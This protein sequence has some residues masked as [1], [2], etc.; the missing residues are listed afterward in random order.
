LT[1]DTIIVGGGSAGCVL[2]N[3]LSADPARRVLLLEA[4]RSAPLDSDIPA[5]WPMMFNT[6][7]DWGYHTEPQSGCRSRRIYWPRGRMIG[8]SGALN[9][10][11]YIRGLPSD[12]DGWEAAGCAGWGWK[13]VLPVFLRSENNARLGNAPLHATG[14]ELTISDVAHVDPVE[15]LWH[16]AAQAAGIPDNADFN[17]ASQE[18]VGWFQLTVKD[19]ERFGTGK[20]F[21]R[22]VLDR[23]N[24]TVRSG[25]LTTRILIENGRAAGVSF[26]DRGVPETVS[27]PEVVLSAGSIGSA[28]LLLL[29]GVGPAEELRALGITPVHDL[30]GVGKNLQDHINIPI[31]FPTRARVGIGGMTGAELDAAMTQWESE[32]AGP[33]TSCWVAAGGF[34]RSTPDVAE[35]DLQLYGV[36]SGHRDHARYLAGGAGFTLHATLQRPRGRGELRLRSADP[37]EHPA[38]DPR[39]FSSDDSGADLATLVAGVRLNRRIA[40]QSPLAEMLGPEHTPS[41][42]AQSDDEIAFYVRS[43]CTTLYHPTSTCRMGT[44][45]LAVVDPRLRVHG[46]QGLTVADASVMPIMVSGNTNAPTIMIAERAA[47]FLSGVR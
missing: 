27:A 30:P 21:L 25:V 12:Y 44:D 9:A 5:N 41:V 36:V 1:Y 47:E 45:A 4:G 40:A 24:L 32:R 26:L 11:I 23:P 33:F 16:Q 18:G 34:A 19:G 17:G 39:Y 28:Q 8:G 42:E 43:H 7:V 15:R 35:P 31:S 13:N 38:L 29:S 46:L 14:G 6:G 3:R 20:A 10:M 37:L 22:P 2:A